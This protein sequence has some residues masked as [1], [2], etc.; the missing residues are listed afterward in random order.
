MHKKNT[1]SKTSYYFF[2][3]I[4][5]FLII[6]PFFWMLSTSFKSRASVMAIPVEWIPKEPTVDSYIKIFTQF[7]FG[8]AILNSAIISVLYT[9]VSVISASMAAFAFA[10][11]NFRGKNLIFK[12]YLAAL[13]IPVQVTLIPLFL[14]MNGLGITNTYASVIIPSLFR[15]F[16]IF[17]LAQQMKM[18]PND[19]I[20]AAKIDGAS[21][22]G[23]WRRIMLPL[24]APTIATL[25]II[26]FMDSWNDYLWPL[27]MLTSSDKLTIPL[28][29]GQLSG[30]FKSDFSVHMAGSLI[31]MIPIIIIYIIAQ[32]YMKDGLSLGGIK[33]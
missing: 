30:Q 5:A 24:S 31:S 16:A 22:F 33:G 8:K 9:I 10:K 15:A 11:L 17:M 7:P 14:I 25:S 13:M 20:Y 29:L 12:L 1:L 27:V 18:I 26:T 3:I 21:Y 4:I 28:A 2:A 6:I 23:I 32:K 19:Y